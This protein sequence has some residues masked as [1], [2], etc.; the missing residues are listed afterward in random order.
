MDTVPKVI[1]IG[2][3]SHVGKSTIAASLAIALGWT[4]VSTD[5]LARHP[6]RPWRSAP[7]KVPD[8]VAEHYLCLSV[9]ELIE[10]V[11]RHYW[12]NVWPK[13]ES[14]IASHSD[15][16]SPNGVVLEGSALWPEFTTSLDFDKIGAVWL[17]ASD[18]L[19]RQRIHA[20]SLYSSKSIREQTMI[21]K[22]L[23]RTIAY[24]ALMVEAVNCHGFTLLDVQRSDAMEIAEKV[25]A[26]LGLAES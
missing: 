3:S 18:E 13:V 16:S 22:F 8:D 21:D 23:K 7:D 15:N 5:S 9:D 19:F 6:G 26:M 2:G 10:D 20:N 14:I 17:T 12:V 4:H 1:L 25:L 24:N 11:L